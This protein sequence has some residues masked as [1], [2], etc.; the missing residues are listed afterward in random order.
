MPIA[1]PQAPGQYRAARR[2]YSRP[3]SSIAPLSTGQRVGKRGAQYRTARRTARRVAGVA[4]VAGA[5]G[6]AS[7]GYC[8]APSTIRELSTQ[9]RV[10]QQATPV[11]RTASHQTSCACAA[12]CC[13]WRRTGHGIARA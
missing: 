9:H 12:P 2:P 5:V 4:E 11:H 3:A 13:A 10:A 7:G 6:A 1:Q 8:C